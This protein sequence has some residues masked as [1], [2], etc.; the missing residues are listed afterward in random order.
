MGGMGEMLCTEPTAERE[1]DQADELEAQ[2]EEETAVV[3]PLPTPDTHLHLMQIQ[4]HQS[5]ARV[6]L[7]E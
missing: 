1:G 2:V 7:E 5:S 6:S 4:R 3:Q